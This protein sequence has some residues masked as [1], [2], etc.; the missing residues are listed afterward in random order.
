M[1][2]RLAS[3]LCAAIATL[4]AIGVLYKFGVSLLS[5]VLALVLLSCPVWVIWMS[6]RLSR[7]T[8]HDIHDAVTKELGSRKKS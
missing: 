7:Q 3:V 5:V 1:K 6:L 4:V 8:N 2:R